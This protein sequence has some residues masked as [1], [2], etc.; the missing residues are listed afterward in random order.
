VIV[1]AGVSI[2]VAVSVHLADEVVEAIKRRREAEKRCVELR[3]ECL[4][5]PT[6]PEWN[7]GTFGDRKACREC[8]RICVR[9]NGKWP[10]EK[11]PRPGSRPGDRWN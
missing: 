9:D 3:D 7:K 8:F 5:S 2:V 4:E 11:C 10:H 6:Q 1:A